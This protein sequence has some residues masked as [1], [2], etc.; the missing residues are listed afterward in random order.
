[1]TTYTLEEIKQAFWG[2]FHESGELWFPNY[3]G[4][5]QENQEVTEEYWYEFVEELDKVKEDK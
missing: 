5:K 3:T 1:M 2:E 4:D